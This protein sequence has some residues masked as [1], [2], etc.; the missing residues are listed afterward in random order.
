VIAL[1][2][3]VL[4]AMFLT[5]IRIA[6]A[7]TLVAGVAATG[8]GLLVNGGASEARNQARPEAQP[9]LA[10]IAA[11]SRSQAGQPVLAAVSQTEAAPQP[12]EASF[13]APGRVIAL[14]DL[15][16][17]W[18]HDPKTKTWHTYKAPK[19]VRVEPQ[20]SRPGSLVAL[21][22]SG[23]PITEVA[24][25][26]AKSGKWSRQAL[27]ELPTDKD[28]FPFLGNNY[29]VYAIGRH[30]YAFSSVT[31]KWAQQVLT[32]PAQV[33]IQNNGAN[34][35]TYWNTRSLHAF[36][37]LT[38]TWAT[39]DLEKGTIARFTIHPGPSG[40]MLVMNGSL[41]YSYDPKKGHFEEVKADED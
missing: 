23:E 18:A 8:L 5:R 19:G 6:I 26:S 2:E 25:F 14:G 1:S 22:F 4:K 34:A 37:G 32:E 3:G 33:Y 9:S 27:V 36:S 35:I 12:T 24:A 7:M 28:V 40:T 41:L 31:G 29:A 13:E 15:Q 20:M 39:M 11:T 10:V 21:K 16:K 30:L 38:G 17:I